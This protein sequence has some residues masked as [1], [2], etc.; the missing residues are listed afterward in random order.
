MNNSDN[1]TMDD[2]L[3]LPGRDSAIIVVQGPT[4]SGKSAL[5]VAI[6]KA[7][8]GVVINAD[9]LQIYSDLSIITARP[10]KEELEAVPHVL[11]GTLSPTEQGTVGSWLVEAVKAVNDARAAGK[12]PVITGGTGMYVRALRQGLAPVPD[13]PETI[14]KEARE[15]MDRLGGEGFRRGL[16][17]YDPEAAARLPSGDTQRLLRAYEVVRATGKTLRDWQDLQTVE[18]PIQGRFLTIALAPP[19]AVIHAAIEKRFDAMMAKGALDEVRALW[20]K[21]LDTE[22]SAMKAVGVRE[23]CAHLNGEVSL[24][25]AV[26]AAK[27][28][29]RNYA[30]RQL[31]WLRT[32]TDPDVKLL[33]EQYSES[34]RPKIFSF[35]RQ[36]LL[37]TGS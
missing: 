1:Q 11:F 9:S 28:S 8:D 7:F 32:Q 16:V 10:S 2:L 21:G 4:A 37:T 17:S 23:L 35:I 25:E 5:G 20:E 27:R 12:I 15:R 14:R 29:T 6:A 19:R 30:K 24:H 3:S 31:T 13:I 34:I 22:L 33:R 26:E 36:F 18:P